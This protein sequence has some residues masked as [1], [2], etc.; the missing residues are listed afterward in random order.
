VRRLDE[1]Y[2]SSLESGS[3]AHASR[4]GP[5]VSSSN[6][7]A[8]AEAGS[9]TRPG[10]NLPRRQRELVEQQLRRVHE[11][12]QRA[13]L[14]LGGAVEAEGRGAREQGEQG[15]ASRCVRKA[16]LLY[17]TRRHRT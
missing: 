1:S 4:L 9:P 3:S 16:C 12:H 14:R 7:G 13:A 11:Q 2:S 17:A 15:E 5:C 10:S 6:G 8:A